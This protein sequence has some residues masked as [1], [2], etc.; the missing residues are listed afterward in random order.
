MQCSLYLLN[1]LSII[2]VIRFVL[3]LFDLKGYW[4]LQEGTA[5]SSLP[6]PPPQP[7]TSHTYEMSRNGFLSRHAGY[8]ISP[9]IHFQGVWPRST[10][11]TLS[12]RV[13]LNLVEEV[14]LA[15]K[16]L[17]SDRSKILRGASYELSNT[18]T[19]SIDSKKR[20]DILESVCYLGWSITNWKNCVDFILSIW[21]RTL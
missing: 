13:C 3:E 18:H 15:V 1:V 21:F 7:Q 9:L 12:H 2:I 5:A 10:W 17:S 19:F 8:E 14:E 4:M 16:F 20:M 6:D 11:Y